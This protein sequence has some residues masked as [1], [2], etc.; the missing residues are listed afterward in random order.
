MRIGIPI[1]AQEINI[2]DWLVAVDSIAIRLYVEAWSICIFI[3]IQQ[4]VSSIVLI[5]T[6]AFSALFSIVTGQL[7]LTL[8]R[9]DMGE[10]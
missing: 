3:G 8:E 9:N 6:V 4:D 7:R 10:V 2:C 1:Q 5:V